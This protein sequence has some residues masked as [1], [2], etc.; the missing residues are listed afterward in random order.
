MSTV[1][2]LHSSPRWRGARLASSPSSSNM[3][4]EPEPQARSLTQLARGRL[5]GY[6]GFRVRT[7]RS[8]LVT[9]GLK[10]RPGHVPITH[11]NLMQRPDTATDRDQ[12][13][14][15]LYMS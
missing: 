14:P 4:I 6:R 7:C 9:L 13:D 10:A 2:V 11:A 12:L 3:I 1:L 5:P 8:C 15:H